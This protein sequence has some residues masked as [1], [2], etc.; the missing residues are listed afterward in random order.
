MADQIK[1]TVETIA[2]TDIR[3]HEMGQGFSQQR[4]STLAVEN[5]KQKLNQMKQKNDVNH[6]V[7][8]KKFVLAR[9]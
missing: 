3:E 5:I 9:F 1:A 6:S 8:L 7:W 4:A 2:L